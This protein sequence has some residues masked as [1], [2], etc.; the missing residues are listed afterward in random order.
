M[1]VHP[2]SMYH[3]SV[4][5]LLHFVVSVSQS[6]STYF[7]LLSPGFPWLSCPI[8][9]DICHKYSKHGTGKQRTSILVGGI[10]T[11]L[12]NMK[13]SWDDYSQYMEKKN[14]PNTDQY[15]ML[16]HSMFMGL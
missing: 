8:S 10:P 14:V 9:S 12:K 16:I 3:V 4:G 13:V 7:L 2:L 11:P 1:D 5:G 15:I 6:E